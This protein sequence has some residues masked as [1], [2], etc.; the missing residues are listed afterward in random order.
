VGG[1]SAESEVHCKACDCSQMGSRLIEPFEV[2]ARPLFENAAN[3]IR[4][5]WSAETTRAK[6]VAPDSAEVTDMALVPLAFS[7][8]LCKYRD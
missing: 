3:C 5:R 8:F 7:P 1:F 6:E 4:A 2:V